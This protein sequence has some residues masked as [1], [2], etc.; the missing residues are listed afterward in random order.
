MKQMIRMLILGG[1]VLAVGA[2][3]Q[4]ALAT[5]S[6]AA[7][8]F[9]STFANSTIGSYSYV[10]NADV[11][12]G[13]GDSGSQ[14]TSNLRGEFWVLTA[15]QPSGE[16]HD[17][18]L[19]GANP[20]NWPALVGGANGTGWIKGPGNVYIDG[21]WAA[22]PNIDGCASVP[23]VNPRCMAIILSD[24]T[25][26]DSQFAVLTK[27]AQS[28][29]NYDFSRVGHITLAR[30][31]KPRITGSSRTGNDVTLQI[32]APLPGD[33]A[34]GSYLD[35]GCSALTGYRIRGKIVPR[36]TGP[37]ATR[38]PATWSGPNT[39]Q[40]A[41]IPIANG[42]SV[43]ADCSESANQ[44]VYL[45]QTFVYDSGYEQHFVSRESTRAECGPQIAQPQQPSRQGSG[46]ERPG[47]R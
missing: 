24:N 7:E 11:P 41:V 16:G 13:G 22:D 45:S 2:G 28:N 36:G 43:V 5:C 44:D 34:A 23:A 18:G 47:R 29:G 1:V 19:G 25:G 26:A 37:A 42:T 35:P 31:P 30:V 46:V 39:F 3:L 38:D 20:N 10:L 33:L 9:S 40:T 15:G 21:A 17:S 27:M 12:S 4:P 32:G 6:G 14:V 8:T